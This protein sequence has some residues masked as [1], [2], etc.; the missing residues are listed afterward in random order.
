[1]ITLIMYWVFVFNM[2]DMV[3]FSCLSVLT[4]ILDIEL[5]IF[6]LLLCGAFNN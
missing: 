3:A 5:I 2:W 4:I 6:I 1:M